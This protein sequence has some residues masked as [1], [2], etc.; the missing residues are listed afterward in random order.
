M[1]NMH[2]INLHISTTNIFDVNIYFEFQVF[3]NFTEL[4]ICAVKYY[5]YF[6]KKKKLLI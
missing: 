3:E 4:P 6:I 1:Y 5:N 2:V